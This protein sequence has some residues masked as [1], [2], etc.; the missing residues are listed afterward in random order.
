MKETKLIVALLFCVNV[1]S[2]SN[3]EKQFNVKSPE[4]DSF[5]KYGNI[6]SMS[7]T[8]ELNYE[9]P[10][11]YT[12][13]VNPLNISLRYDASGFR[14]NK[15]P[16][17]VGLNWYLNMGGVITR[18]INGMPD[19]QMGEPNSNGAQRETNGFLVGTR[20]KIHNKSN[21]FIFNSLDG[22]LQALNQ[23][24]YLYGTDLYNNYE[25][26]PDIFNFNFNGISGKFFV[27]NDGKIKVI[28]N[29]SNYL[30]IDISGMQNQDIFNSTS[31][32]SH[33]SLIIITDG[34]GNK[35]YFGGENKNLEYSISVAAC[36]E[37]S[38]N[39]F[40][41]I[42]AWHLYKIVHYNGKTTNFVYRDDSAL[43]N[44]F[45]NI[46]IPAHG[47]MGITNPL[48]DFLSF[49][50][51]L[52]DTRQASSYGDTQLG[53]IGPGGFALSKSI[54][55]IAILNQINNDDFIINFSYSKQT[56]PFYN[57][58]TTYNDIYHTDCGIF[59]DYKDIKLDQINFYNKIGGSI[60]DLIKN[61]TFGYSYLGGTYSRLFLTNLTETG[62]SP[63]LFEYNDTNNLPKPLTKG[64]DHWGYWNGKNSDTNSLIPKQNYNF[65]YDS[66]TGDYSSCNDPDCTTRDPNNN[67]SIKGILSKVSYPTGGYTIFDYEA[68]DYSYRLESKSTNN[69]IPS[70][71]NFYGICG[72]T[73]IKKIS[74]FDGVTI[75]NVKTYEYK[76]D[77]SSSSG[78]LLFWPRYIIN[79]KVPGNTALDQEFLYC[80]SNPTGNLTDTAIMTY[81]QVSEITNGNG[82]KVTKYTDFITNPD[83]VNSNFYDTTMGVYAIPKNLSR[84]Y[85]GYNLND[86]SIE[87]GKP[88]Y[89]MVYDNTNNLIEKIDYTFNSDL[90]RFDEWSAKLHLSGSSI[91]SNK[92]YYYQ[93][94]LTQ[95]TTTEY[96]PTGDFVTTEK[97]KY[98][99]A[100]TY[101]SSTSP[102]DI[103]LKKSMVTSLNNQELETQYK[104]P[105]DAY[106]TTSANYLNFVNANIATSIGE[107]QYRNSIKLSEKFTVYA[108]DATTNNL[109][110][111]KNEYAAK[112]PNTLPN[113]TDVGTLEKVFT[114]DSYDTKGNVTQYTKE[115]GS[116]VTLIWGYNQV[117]LIAKIENA[118]K[119]QV[120]TALLVTN[121]E[122]VNE[123]NLTAIDALRTNA[124]FSNSLITTYTHKPLVGVL[125]ITD[126]KGDIKKINY[127]SAGRLINVIDKD[128][129]ILNENIYNYNH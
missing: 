60:G 55:K 44:N 10:L 62:K 48:T 122:T 90:N 111:P 91:Q 78:I 106:S 70:L 123:T 53:G 98:G 66:T 28:G 7:Y 129:K 89:E 16:G 67:F 13:N 63:Y 21:A 101:S 39:S 72:G 49:S 50:N 24:Y 43:N 108:K 9:I 124:S 52:N 85:N 120:E 47:G 95:K 93:D 100:P 31:K 32:P 57:E 56:N 4:I 2:Q 97:Y 26:D 104:F 109:L 33:P 71:Y 69:Y 3:L 76:N 117:L 54:Q 12:N 81:S 25:G 121:I 102:Q 6:S 92:I 107:S 88:L 82:K 96:T 40:Q 61:I 42:T 86:K 46:P 105:W 119:A 115:N 51:Y 64:I 58:D 126:P 74:D 65:N 110:L 73:R 30:K 103:L 36:N 127:D 19:D 15:K 14:P 20:N 35:Y 83:E 116:P 99:T 5:I 128:D 22:F 125:S 8:G 113:V 18:E 29:E 37:N 1:F 27:G 114:Y 118:T 68:H 23:N 87:R 41:N 59:D 94:Y 79:W 75:T 38:G 34:N 45:A 84:N 11:I 112:F 80:K 77:N 17:L